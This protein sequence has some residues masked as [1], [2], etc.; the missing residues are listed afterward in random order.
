[1]AL[2]SFVLRSPPPNYQPKAMREIEQTKRKYLQ[3]YIIL[4]FLS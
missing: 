1:M 4:K 2:A 3:M